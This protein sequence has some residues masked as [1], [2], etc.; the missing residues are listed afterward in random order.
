MR[1]MHRFRWKWLSASVEGPGHI[2]SSTP[3]QDR[4]QVTL[5]DGALVAVVAD[6][7]GSHRFSDKGAAAA[8]VSVPAAVRLWL[9]KKDRIVPDLLRLVQTMWLMEI[10]P[11]EP[12]ECG[13]TCLFAVM[14]PDGK[15]FVCQLGDGLILVYAHGQ[16]MKIVQETKDGFSNQTTALSD[17]GILKHWRWME[18]SLMQKGSSIFLIT[19]GISEDLDLDKISDFPGI[20]RK[21]FGLPSRRAERLIRNELINWKTPH[22]MDDKSIIAVMRK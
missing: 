17:K 13:C 10:R 16:D 22:H 20:F 1:W 4:V 19:D 9:V 14:I 21:W 12:S 11:L 7:I 8:C 5:L 6:G 18:C 3:N 15:A 2:E